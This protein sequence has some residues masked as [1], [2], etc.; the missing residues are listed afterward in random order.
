MNDI[1]PRRNA[2][3]VLQA[4]KLM[5]ALVRKNMEMVTLL[6]ATVA[7]QDE[8]IRILEAE[9]NE[10]IVAAMGHGPTA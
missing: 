4:L 9:K 1:I 6:G 5:D 2:E 3:G 8:R 10:R 7:S